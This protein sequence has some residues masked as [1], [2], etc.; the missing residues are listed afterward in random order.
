MGTVAAFIL[1]IFAG[2]LG[3]RIDALGLGLPLTGGMVMLFAARILDGITG[4]NITI[5][6]AYVSDITRDEDRAQGLGLLQAAFGAG[7]VFGPA[8]GGLLGNFGPVMPFVGATIVTTATLLLTVFTL[9]ESLSPEERTAS[10]EKGGRPR[11]ALR[12][13]LRERTLLLMLT[14]G[15]LASLAFS[16]LPSIFSLFADHVVFAEAANQERI[17]LYIGLMLAFLG[18]AQ[19]ITQL[20]LVRPLVEKLGERRLMILGQVVLLLSFGFLAAFSNAVV[21]TL[22]LGTFAFGTGVSEP[23]MQALVTRFGGRNMRGHLLGLYQSARSLA[24]IG[25]PIMAGA[26]YENI[27]PQAAFWAG[28]AVMGLALVGAVML[29]NREIKPIEAQV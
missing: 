1:F 28:T 26:I 9:E 2:P 15:F 14:I 19:V 6:Q 3:A 20:R 13:A 4:G 10:Q 11:L 27:F 5:A 22:L 24:L 17:S 21:V 29:L 25:G 16:S 8:F 18:I 7:F 23:T 12:V